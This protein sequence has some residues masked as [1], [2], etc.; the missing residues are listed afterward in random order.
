MF[1]NLEVRHLHA[2]IV[3]AEELNFTRAADRLHITQPALSKQIT[4]LE[5]E[6]RFHLFTRDTRRVVEL[7]D[8]GRAFVEEVALRSS[9]RSGLCISLMLHT[10]GPIA[11]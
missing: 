2:V 7:T 3:L 1:P 10:T 11:F 4:D 9:I 8:A 6:H 5:A